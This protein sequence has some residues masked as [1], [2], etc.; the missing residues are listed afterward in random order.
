MS[1]VLPTPVASAKHSEGNSR[2]KLVTVGNY[3]LIFAKRVSISHC[4]LMGKSSQ[5]RARISNDCRCG[6]RGMRRLAILLTS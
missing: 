1:R 5:I 6:G 4:L 3:W 2:S